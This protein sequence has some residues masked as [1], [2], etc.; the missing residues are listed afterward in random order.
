MQSTREG[1]RIHEPFSRLEYLRLFYKPVETIEKLLSRHF[2]EVIEML[3]GFM[4]MALLL[5]NVT[6]TQYTTYG[7]MYRHSSLFG[8]SLFTRAVLGYLVG[9]FG[10]YLYT[11]V[12]AHFANRGLKADTVHKVRTAFAWGLAP[13]ALLTI[14]FSITSNLNPDLYD[15]GMDLWRVQIH[16]I[17]LTLFMIP[18][19][20]RNIFSCL[21]TVIHTSYSR[22]L[23][24]LFEASMAMALIVYG[25][26]MLWLALAWVIVSVSP[27]IG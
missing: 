27:I 26:Y 16:M 5:V 2:T 15:I 13:F 1:I 12:V 11:A 25:L 9:Y 19:S 6:S 3:M 24:I 14:V 18:L 17:L 8:M 21:K 4:G 7:V 23:V 10:F 20:L 22:V